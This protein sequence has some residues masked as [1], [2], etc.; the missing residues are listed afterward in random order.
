[1]V[2]GNQVLFSV[3]KKFCLEIEDFLNELRKKLTENDE[4]K[5]M[6]E[7]TGINLF[8]EIEEDEEIEKDEEIKEIKK[9]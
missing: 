9:N 4:N 3:N 5:L 2:W 7:I 6:A 1:M 8:I